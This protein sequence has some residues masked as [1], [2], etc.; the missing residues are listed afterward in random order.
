[1][2][3]KKKYR[4]YLNEYWKY[5]FILSP[6]NGQLPLC[7]VCKKAFSNEAVK[8]SILSDHLAK[9]HSDKV[10]SL[11][12]SQCGKS[13]TIGEAFVLLPVKEIV[14]T[15]L[16]PA[17]CAM[18]K[19][20]PLSN[21]TISRRIHE[22]AADVE[23]T[24]LDVLKN[25]EFVMQIDESTVRDNE[26]LLLASVHNEEVVEELLVEEFFQEK[27]IPLTNCV[28]LTTDGAASIIGQY[29]RF[30][31]DLKSAIP[32]IMAVHCVIHR[33]HLV[34]EHLFERLHDSLRYVINV[35]N[36]IKAYSL[37]EHLFCN[38]CQGH[39]EEF[40]RLLHTKV[41]WLSRGKCLRCFYILFD[42][43]VEFLQPIDPS[44]CDAIELRRLDVAYFADIF[45]K[46]NKSPQEIAREDGDKLQDADL[47]FFCS[48]LKQAKEDMQ[49]RFHDLCT[50]EIPT[51]LG[52][53]FSEA[54][55]HF[56]QCG[57]ECFWMKRGF[58]MVQ[59]LLTK[60]RNKLQICVRGDL[61]LRLPKMEPDNATLVLSHLAQGSH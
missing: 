50:L 8:L 7:L 46:L 52:T 57:Y 10:V 6:A 21:D 58:S 9:M 39:D 56:Q 16:G 48:H 40:K 60:A 12:I 38:L 20:I 14:S 5:R 3:E 34:A 26:A 36:K 47:D 33:Q 27:S 53:Q 11:L 29:R 15:M 25:T 23:E 55:A 42:T 45:D 37:N 18:V 19:S 35:V 30:I 2:A 22:M 54:Q 59:Q 49:T 17:A 31:A 43:V 24:P 4:Q 32:G 41:R 51:Q 1:M 44:L 61:R 28:P 13:H